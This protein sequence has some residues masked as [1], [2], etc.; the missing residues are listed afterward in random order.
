NF[1]SLLSPEELDKARRTAS[2]L[3]ETGT[4][5]EPT[6][7]RL[8]CKSGAYLDVET[9]GAVIPY[10]T[11]RAILGI[12]R[13]ITERRKAQD[14]LRESEER[15]RIMADHCPTLIWVSD[16]QGGSQFVNRA[17][18]DFFQTTYEKLEARNWQPFVHPEDAPQYVGSFMR[19]VRERARYQAEA[20]VRR[21]DGA[22]RWIASYAEPRFSA[23]GDFLGHVGLSMD[24][25]DRKQAEDA[26][27]RSE[28]KFRQLAE[29]IREVFWMR[30]T[31]PNEILYVSPGFE[32][33][34][35]RSPEELYRNPLAWAMAIEPEDRDSVLSLFERQTRGEP[36]LA[37]YRIRTPRGEVKWIRDRAFPVRDAEGRVIRVAGLAEDITLYKEAEAALRDAKE[38]AEAA[39]RAKSE[40]LANMSHEIRTPMNGVIGMAGLLLDTELSEEQRE[41]A[42]IV[43]SSAE[44]LLAVINDILDFSKVEAGKLEMEVVDFDI[45]RTV[46]DAIQ[47]L[48]A[49]AERK[50]LTLE[51]ETGA[52]IP[53]RVRGDPGRLR[54]VL[55]NLVGNAVKFTAQ[56][57]V[58]VRARLDRE[59]E[60]SVM[61]RISVEDTGIGIPADRQADIFSPFTQVDGSTTRRFGGTG[62]GLAIARQ[63]VGLMGGEIGVRSEEG[64]GATFWFTAV[65][66]KAPEPAGAG[67]ERVGGAAK[68]AQIGRNLAPLARTGRIL[69]AED[70]TTNQKVI[71]AI[72]SKFGCRADAVANGHEALASLRR[73]PYDLVLLDCQMPEMNGCDTAV[74]IRNPRSGVVNPDIPIIAV[75]ALA[76]TGDREKCLMAGMSDYLAKPVEPAALAAMLDKWLPARAGEA[77]AD[78]AVR[79]RE[80]PSQVAVFDEKSL[81]DRVLGDR[82]LAQLLVAGFLEDIPRQLAALEARLLAGD[83]AG[84]ERQAHSIRGAAANVSGLGV[85]RVAQAIEE[86]GRVGDLRGMAV[87]FAEL[88]DQYRAVKAAMSGLQT[89]GKRT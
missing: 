9:M 32:H 82:A 62:L 74:M 12:A 67:P 3:R 51:S 7:F 83:V 60:R 11:G 81:F 69:V 6:D 57:G 22:W 86:A 46:E 72:L 65:F 56:G 23:S 66:G 70:D 4:Q 15:F 10:G 47:L 41:Y 48:G 33:V 79:M 59:E 29:N 44:S 55:L 54:Q 39:N 45:R 37:E 8:K 84:A 25:T 85:Q 17:Y 78:G 73:I 75:T 5:R 71:L 16:A 40:F 24:I 2:E 26:L 77:P 49:E 27:R 38:K 14:A 28:E 18:L 13:N 64:K 43:R 20:R 63:L 52:G 50:G 31:E 80:V 76:M 68:G 53:W 21:G 19:A 36:T 30:N 61:V 87:Q 42:E 1:T 35:G 58:K 34:W 88:E 89:G